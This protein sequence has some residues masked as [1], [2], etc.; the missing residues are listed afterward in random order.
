MPAATPFTR[1][2]VAFTPAVVV[3]ELVQVPPV[4]PLDNAVVDPTHT[5]W[6]PLIAVGSALTVNDVV[7]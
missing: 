3:D 7:T 1:P 2:V 5:D 4:G 6:V